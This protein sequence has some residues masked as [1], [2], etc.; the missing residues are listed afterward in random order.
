MK[1]FTARFEVGD[2]VF[3]AL[4]DP[5]GRLW[6]LN[7]GPSPRRQFLKRLKKIGVESSPEEAPSYLVKALYEELSSYLAGENKDPRFPLFLLGTPFEK[8][9]WRDLKLIPYGET[10]T[11][12][13]L[14]EVLGRKG[15]QRAVG[16]ALATN[17]IPIF[18]PCHRIVAKKGL[19][20]FSQGLEIKRRLLQLEKAFSQ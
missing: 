1:L 4:L 3:T 20:G 14:A 19:G 9:V 5:K 2:I 10:R 13:W 6:H 15:A 17:P 12:A 7:F 8:E 18:I 16:R 11:Y